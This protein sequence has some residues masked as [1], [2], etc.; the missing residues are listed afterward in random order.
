MCTGGEEVESCEMMMAGG[1][2]KGGSREVIAITGSPLPRRRKVLPAKEGLVPPSRLQ[3]D[4]T[5]AV[6]Y[7]QL[8]M[9]RDG[10]RQPT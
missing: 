2:Q 9:D 6:L 5:W 3:F 4:G 7:S 1:S 8:G 10:P